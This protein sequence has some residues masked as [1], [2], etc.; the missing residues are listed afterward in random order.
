MYCAVAEY[1][2]IELPDS[3]G[4]NRFWVL[5]PNTDSG[6]WLSEDQARELYLE[7]SRQL[8]DPTVEPI[9]QSPHYFQD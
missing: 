6:I 7:L 1:H 4:I 2:T 9:P 5:N 3:V 8:F